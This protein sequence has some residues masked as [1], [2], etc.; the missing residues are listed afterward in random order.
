MPTSSPTLI[1]SEKTFSNMGVE[2]TYLT[3]SRQ[4]IKTATLQIEFREGESERDFRIR[5]DAELS[6]AIQTTLTELG[7]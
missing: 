3:G 7:G 1:L 2:I 6:A 5:R 4:G